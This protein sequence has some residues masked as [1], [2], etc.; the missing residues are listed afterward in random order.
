MEMSDASICNAFNMYPY[1]TMSFIILI[2]EYIY[3]SL[4]KFNYSSIGID[5]F[6]DS[7]K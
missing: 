2:F 4:V 6:I 3:L 1:D 7:L 5:C